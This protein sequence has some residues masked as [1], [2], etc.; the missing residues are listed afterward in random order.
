MTSQFRIKNQY[1]FLLRLGLSIFIF[2]IPYLACVNASSEGTASEK[3][4]STSIV[5]YTS[6]TD[7]V[8][9]PLDE[10]SVPSD[11]FLRKIFKDFVI[12]KYPHADR[13]DTMNFL[14]RLIHE[15]PDTSSSLQKP[16]S[17]VTSVSKKEEQEKILAQLKSSAD[18]GKIEIIVESMDKVPLQEVGKGSSSSTVLEPQD[19]HLCDWM[20]QQKKKY[21][22][23]EL[24]A[25]QKVVSVVKGSDEQT[26]KLY[27][28]IREIINEHIKEALVSKFVSIPSYSSLEKKW[29]ELSST[30]KGK[31][32]SDLEERILKNL[33]LKK[34]ID[35]YLVE[36]FTSSSKEGSVKKT[37]IKVVAGTTT[38]LLLYY[39]K[40][41]F[42]TDTFIH[43]FI[44]HIVMGGGLLYNYPDGIK[45][46]LNDNY[47]D[48]SGK[49][50]NVSVDGFLR[51]KFGSLL[52]NLK[53]KDVYDDSAS[54]FAYP[55][56][57]SDGP[58][59]VGQQLGKYQSSAWAS[60]TGILPGKI[61]SFLQASLAAQL[62]SSGYYQLGSHMMVSAFMMDLSPISYFNTKSG[63]DSSDPQG[64]SRNYALAT[65][66]D[67]DSIFKSTAALVTLSLPFA[68]MTSILAANSN[69]EDAIPDSL[70]IMKFYKKI[71]EEGT[72]SL[73][74]KLLNSYS[75]KEKLFEL[76]KVGQGNKSTESYRLAAS[77]KVILEEVQ[78]FE[79][80][81]KSKK[82]NLRPLKN[83]LLA[84]YDKNLAPLNV[85]G[86]GV[87][88]AIKSVGNTLF[89]SAPITKAIGI[90]GSLWAGMLSKAGAVM[91]TISAGVDLVGSGIELVRNLRSTKMVGMEKVAQ[92][93]LNVVEMGALAGITGLSAS[94]AD[95]TFNKNE[96]TDLTDLLGGYRFL[97]ITCLNGLVAACE[98]S[99]KQ[100][101]QKNINRN[102]GQVADELIPDV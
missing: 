22:I 3:A 90:N 72:D 51:A 63:E 21:L 6:M 54:G 10:P 96:V 27:L 31:I 93:V 15:N 42:G 28:S 8:E 61:L 14:E 53:V 11:H 89:Y 87:L 30:E 73:E 18:A 12:S 37:A 57:F 56:R 74:Y 45:L 49:D 29:S 46:V 50:F 69:L 41:I 83:E 47:Y 34:L 44:G 62:L 92:T 26:D 81:L 16:Q 32:F 24:T 43:E 80:Y 64:F 13:I 38:A 9:I 52:D 1:S 79:E 84:S 59:V 19:E 76:L 91:G 70:A 4:A 85:K 55:S 101:L 2:F 23:P 58:S 97:G 39:L 35:Q 94:L 86:K 100:L 78:K 66:K 33:S 48:K 17:K 71:M 40:Q 102:I 20:I 95:E 36:N 82:Y 67:Q 98:Y 7:L 68:M 77:P 60:L 25:L 5:P 88:S 99:K 65:G 75:G